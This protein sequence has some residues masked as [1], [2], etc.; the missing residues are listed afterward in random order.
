M[1][2]IRQSRDMRGG[3][4]FHTHGPSPEQSTI[5]IESGSVHFVKGES[6]K[7]TKDRQPAA[8]EERVVPVS[9]VARRRVSNNASKT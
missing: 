9:S 5:N 6:K 2:E 8:V 7:S 4:L 1:A 3:S